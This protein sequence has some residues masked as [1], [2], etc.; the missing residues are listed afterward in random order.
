MSRKGGKGRVREREREAHHHPTPPSQPLDPTYFNS[1]PLLRLNNLRLFRA[2]IYTYSFSKYLLAVCVDK[3]ST[4]LLTPF[5]KILT[6]DTFITNRWFIANRFLNLC[7]QI[8]M[9][10][11]RIAVL[12]LQNDTLRNDT[13]IVRHIYIKKNES[14][15][16]NYF[17]E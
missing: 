2:H 9:A 6:H 4:L 17:R 5:F 8:N 3:I 11:L 16:V 13:S 12:T 14:P 7:V 10:V 1:F 15:V